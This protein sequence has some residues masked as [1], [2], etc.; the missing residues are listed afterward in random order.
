MNAKINKKISIIS[1]LSIVML[2]TFI[3]GFLAINGKNFSHKNFV[4]CAAEDGETSQDVKPE[5]AIFKVDNK[6]NVRLLPDGKGIKFHAMMNNEYYSWLK[7]KYPDYTYTIKVEVNRFENPAE[8]A[9]VSETHVL[10]DSDFIGV[11]GETKAFNYAYTITYDDLSNLTSDQLNKAYATV[12]KAEASVIVSKSG[13]EDIVE[14]ADGCSIRNMM[15]VA[16]YIVDNNLYKSESDKATLELYFN[17]AEASSITSAATIDFLHKATKDGK[18]VDALTFDKAIAED[19]SLYINAV[20]LNKI[21]STQFEISEELKSQ[22]KYDTDYTVYAFDK[23]NKSTTFT[24]HTYAGVIYDAND[25][26]SVFEISEDN[27]KK[28]AKTVQT[29]DGSTIYGNIDRDF[30]GNYVLANDISLSINHTGLNLKYKQNGFIGNI[31]QAE[32][33]AVDGTLKN[34]FFSGSFD[35]QGHKVSVTFDQAYSNAG[36]FGLFGEGALIENLMINAVSTPSNNYIICKTSLGKPTFNNCYFALTETAPRS[37]ANH[38]ISD[39]LVTFKNSIIDYSGLSYNESSYGKLLSLVYREN[40]FENVILLGEKRPFITAGN[41]D[42]YAT[43]DGEANS[44]AGTYRFDSYAD[45]ATTSSGIDFSGFNTEYWD[46][47]TVG[48]PVYKQEGLSLEFALEDYRNGATLRLEEGKTFDVSATYFGLPVKVEITDNSGKL[49]IA[50]GNLTADSIGSGTMQVSYTFDG[51]AVSYTVKYEVSKKAQEVTTEVYYS[52]VDKLIHGL[53]FDGDVTSVYQGANGVTLTKSDRNDGSYAVSGLVVADTK[54]KGSTQLLINTTVGS[55]KFINVVTVTKVIATVDDWAYMNI[56]ADDTATKDGYVLVAN[57]VDTTSMINLHTTQNKGSVWAN[58]DTVG[59][60]G[61][62]AATLGLRGT[63]DGNGKTIKVKSAKVGIFGVI[64]GLT[65]KDVC[66]IVDATAEYPVGEG[67]DSR[68]NVILATGMSDFT[69]ENVVVKVNSVN[70][71]YNNYTLEK[72]YLSLANIIRQEASH[73]MTMKNIVVDYGTYKMT[74]ATKTGGLLTVGFCQAPVSAQKNCVIDNIYIAHSGSYRL[75]CY[76]D[77]SANG[78]GNGEYIVQ[79]HTV[80]AGN[81]EDASVVAG[82]KT[83]LNIYRY[84]DVSSLTSDSAYTGN[85]GMKWSYSDSNGW[86]FAK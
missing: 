46:I 35:G 15:A 71:T 27:V 43:N 60:V 47:T 68:V 10:T 34:L 66:F 82:K 74:D 17:S 67:A 56:G 2:V 14:K 78:N 18:E 29:I 45:F 81:E 59:K 41:K 73:P 75:S 6:A 58:S 85:S 37:G 49:S 21:S 31:T 50:D 57:D 77:P 86:T 64:N 32:I 48:V 51:K 38:R 3:I 40:A 39:Q 54:V 80:Y 20:P 36:L 8:S 25:F 19:Y 63:F 24:V 79:S 70:L 7:S 1:L 22:L 55:Y 30:S 53:S 28:Y 4:V 69:L 62:W 12:L 42:Y 13:E 16:K 44:V 65:I 72:T 52:A 33:N 26:K 84:D 83:T 11:D 61:G 5:G 9:A 76:S 23:D